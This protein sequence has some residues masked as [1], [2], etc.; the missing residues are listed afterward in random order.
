M[1]SEPQQSVSTLPSDFKGTNACAEIKLHPTGKFLY[2]S[3]RGHD[4]IARFSVN[5]HSGELTAL[6]QTPTEKTPRSFDLDSTGRFL[7][8]A[9]ES[10][11]KVAAYRVDGETG[12]LTR[13][14]TYTVG[15][16]PWWV[17]VV[18]TMR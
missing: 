13:T 18:G 14:E 2:V 7:Y 6:G 8:A 16:T 3:N 10:T 11:G 15:S 4:S 9:G 17:L 1:A 12:E 5:E